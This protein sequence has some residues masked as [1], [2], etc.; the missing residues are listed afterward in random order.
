[1]SEWPRASASLATLRLW[2]GAHQKGD[3]KT[4]RFYDLNLHA[5]SSITTF[6]G[7]V[8]LSLQLSSLLMTDVLS[9]A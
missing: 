2:V 4:A 6:C 9:G 5:H 7:L 3:N 8:G 1:M